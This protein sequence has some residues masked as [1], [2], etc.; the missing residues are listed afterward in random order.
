M[1]GVGGKRSLPGLARIG[2]ASLAWAF[3][4]CAYAYTGGGEGG[5]WAPVAVAQGGKFLAAAVIG[6]SSPGGCAV[7]RA[8]LWGGGWK[9]SGETGI[10]RRYAL[11][12]S[13][14]GSAYW[15]FFLIAEGAAGAGAATICGWA[16]F[17]VILVW[18]RS[19]AAPA[20]LG[21]WAAV[22]LAAGGASLSI[23]GGTGDVGNWIAGAACGVG[24]GAAGGIYVERQIWWTGN[25]SPPGRDR[26]P[27]AAFSGAFAGFAGF[28][29]WATVS[30]I[31]GWEITAQSAVILA[32]AGMVDGA[33]ATVLRTGNLGV[34]NAASNAVS[35]PSA[36][37]AV[38]AVWA[39]GA[40]G[41]QN[42]PLFWAGAAL[43]FGGGLAA[44]GA[45][46][47]SAPDR[48][49]GAPLR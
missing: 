31:W 49:G 7:W 17:L 33:G 12:L 4:V 44:I 13:A 28:L 3:L 25:A 26:G 18:L 24:M 22:A 39:L 36:P 8:A 16:A 10:W 34:S 23:A 21:G 1:R 27:T 15:A 35:A 5:F 30:F 19:G 38:A 46:T 29:L 43:A 2:A 40:G 47:S 11:P 42:G 37:L 9:A 32:V 20:G 14:L 48:G 6:L 45:E 41:I